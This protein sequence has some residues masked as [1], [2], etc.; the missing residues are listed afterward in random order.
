MGDGG[1]H[2]YRRIATL[3]ETSWL[4]QA[5]GLLQ[6]SFTP[7]IFTEAR[8][9]LPPLARG[10]RLE[11]PGLI[12]A[13]V[14]LVAGFVIL[15]VPRES[16]FHQGALLCISAE[17]QREEGG[18]ERHSVG[19][20]VPSYL[21]YCVFSVIFVSSQLHSSGKQGR[22]RLIRPVDLGKPQRKTK[23]RNIEYL[24]G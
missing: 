4:T 14:Q 5:L 22:D 24:K 19:K 12:A 11:A 7:K 17:L 20:N 8:R 9:L 15:A 1:G 21:W 10:L 13:T 18:K 6:F 16:A 3:P 2:T 23:E